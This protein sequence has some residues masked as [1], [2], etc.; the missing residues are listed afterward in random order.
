MG[1]MFSQQLMKKSMRDQSVSSLIASR[2]FNKELFL[3]ILRYG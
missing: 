2:S 1:D 3:C